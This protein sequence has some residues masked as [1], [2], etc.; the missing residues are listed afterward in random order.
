VHLAAT[1]KKGVN[2]P[3][4]AVGKIGDPVL[5]EQILR[6][7]K[8]DFMAMA[9]ALF[10]DPELPNKAKKG[11]LGDITR[12]LYCNNCRLPSDTS[13]IM[14]SLKLER[15][16]TVNSSV[17]RERDFRLT[18]T[19]SSKKVMVIGGGL[20][21]METARIAAKRGHE[22]FLYEQTDQLGGQW[23]IASLFEYKRHFRDF[24]NQ[25]IDRLHNS[26]AVIILNEKVTAELVQKEKP[27]VVVVAT[28]AQPKSLDVPGCEEYGVQSVDVLTDQVTVGQRVIVVGGRL[29]GMEIAYMLASKG[30]KVILVTK[31]RLGENG[32]PLERNIF[33]NLKDRLAETGVHICTHSCLFE[34]R[35]R[36]VYINCEGELVY[37]EADTV[38]LAVGFKP[39][40]KILKELEG[41]NAQVYV[42]GDCLEPRNAKD[43]IN[44]GATVG[45]RI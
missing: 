33:V 2:V 22:V 13:E 7:G 18:R 27:D 34:V 30:K 20:A 41:I 8:A 42:V 9:R 21:G 32:H 23:N 15:T 6:E 11:N 12:C 3:V 26:G 10:A 31:N 14:K 19:K 40:D 43:A 17:L 39:N 1:I 44:E 36:G 24:T 38:I 37:L 28:G 29:V 35:K 4:I 25:L 5:A 16:C 45:L